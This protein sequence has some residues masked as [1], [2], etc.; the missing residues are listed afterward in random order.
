MARPGS[1]CGVRDGTA[2]RL[3]RCGSRMRSATIRA[4][5]RLAPAPPGASPPTSLRWPPISGPM[6]VL[7]L[8]ASVARGEPTAPRPDG[9]VG[10]IVV[11]AT[12]HDVS[13]P[14]RELAREQGAVPHVRAED[15]TPAFDTPREPAAV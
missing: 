13:R 1:T 11:N 10:P 8:L 14:L 5:R 7:F 9:L 3:R 12:W 4:M 2:A 15:G 6:R